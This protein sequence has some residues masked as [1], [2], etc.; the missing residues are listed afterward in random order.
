MKPRPIGSAK[1][2]WPTTLVSKT[3]DKRYVQSGKYWTSAGV[4]AGIDM[5]LGV[6][7]DLMG[8]KYT[9]RVMLDME[10]DPQPPVKGGSEHNTDKSL[11]ESSR[12]M[13]NNAI[14]PLLNPQKAT[15]KNKI[16][17]KND[18]VCGMTMGTW[19]VDTV[20]YK[21]KVYGFCS[22]LCKSTFKKAPASYLAHAH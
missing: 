4:S 2:Y 1:K 11:V 14:A 13:F 20:H 3:L 7:N 5:S 16:D 21:G 6:V 22:A 9:Q 8:E 15:A 12:A 19:A 10:Y 17:N 18:L